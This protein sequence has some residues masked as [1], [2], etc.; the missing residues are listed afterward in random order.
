MTDPKLN[1]ALVGHGIAASRT[2]EMHM[3]EGRAQGLRYRYDRFDT[4]TAPW[5]GMPLADIIAEA[6][7]RG[8]AGLNVTHP[9]K[10]A[11]AQ[12]VDALEGEARTLGAINTIVFSG[13]RTRGHNTDYLG[14]GN[15][16]AQAQGL[17]TRRRVLLLGAGGAAGAVALALLDH[18]T[19]E[20]WIKDLDPQKARSLAGM[21]S[22]H[23]PSHQIDPVDDPD[24][25]LMA[26]LDGIVNATPMGMAAY[27]GEAIDV[28]LIHARSWV[29]DIVYFPLQT[30]L[31]CKAQA[32]GCVTMSG[33]AM[34]IHQASAAFR[35]FTGRQADLA[36]MQRHFEQ[37]DPSTFVNRAHHAPT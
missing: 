34:A 8:F 33:A 20:L 30:S 6:R 31:L 35:L 7:R 3:A 37:L 13:G 10:I 1:V 23:R 9:F 4:G 2:P 5:D 24:G 12:L 36:R 18:G 11:A 17:Q 14:F 15:A 28:G 26:R 29:A 25:A 32:K 27:P 21:L 16:L 22:R 19:E